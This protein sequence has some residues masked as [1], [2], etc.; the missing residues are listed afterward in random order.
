MKRMVILIIAVIL[1]IV[2]AFNSVAYVVRTD[3][4]AVV[5]RFGKAIRVIQQPGLYFK[6]PMA[7]SV[8]KYT[9]KLLEYDAA[10]VTV[11]TQDKKSIMLDTIA[12]FRITD[13]L[14]FYKRVR[15]VAGAQER[16]DDSIYSAVRVVIGKHTY[17]EI[18]YQKRDEIYRAISEMA[19]DI[20]REYG[21][22]VEAV[23]FKRVFI[24]SENEQAIYQSMIAER[25][26]VAAK[27]RA[28]GQSEA[29][30][31]KSEADRKAKEIL[32][33]AKRQAEI[34]K[35]EGDAKAQEI[36][37]QAASEA[38]EF[39]KFLQTIDFYRDNLKNTT[40]VLTPDSELFK[41]LK[42]MGVVKQ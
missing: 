36:I 37:S 5:L 22:S 3:Q 29:T 28:E 11:V 24:P 42:Q 26:R 40:I 30:R 1:L 31:I 13:P 27:L 18:L 17:D 8:V 15:T 2:L 39:Y 6:L 32:A 4:Q 14:T 19:G 25:Q 10:P 23:M 41:Y 20:S 9:K 38:P 16:L 34:L 35:G 21:V 33:D 12:L 7:D